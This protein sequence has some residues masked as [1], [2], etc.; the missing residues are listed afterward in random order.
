[1]SQLVHSD[2]PLA[3]GQGTQHKLMC[4]QWN[5]NMP[6]PI[7][8][9]HV[10]SSDNKFSIKTCT[11]IFETVNYYKNNLKNYEFEKGSRD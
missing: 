8:V 3:I 6:I 7:I 5:E 11:K 4:F 10:E 1:M 9:L 2:R